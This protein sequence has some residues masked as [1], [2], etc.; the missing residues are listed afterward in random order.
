MIFFEDVGDYQVN[1]RHFLG[2]EFERGCCIFPEG[3]DVARPINQ[4]QGTHIA[5]A[6]ACGDEMPSLS[7]SAQA[8]DFVGEW[9]GSHAEGRKPVVI[10]LRETKYG[11]ARNSNRA[12]WADF[13]RE[14]D[15]AVYLPV[16][17]RDTFAAFD[18]GLP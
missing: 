15:P 10:T 13:A 5:A 1:F 2:I 12:A 9:L 11:V 7:A 8:R 6:V 3:Y 4:F 17:V 18:R 14:L 16:I